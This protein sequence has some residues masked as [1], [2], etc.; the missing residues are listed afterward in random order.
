MNSSW[1]QTFLSRWDSTFDKGWWL[2]MSSGTDPFITGATALCSRRRVDGTWVTE[3][4]DRTGG[5]FSLPS[6]AVVLATGASQSQAWLLQELVAGEPLL[7]RFEGKTRLSGECLGEAGA[8]AIRESLAGCISPRAAIVGSSHSAMAS[9]LVC[10]QTVG[11]ARFGAGAITLMHRKPLRLTYKSPEEAIKD[12]FTNFGAAD[13]CLKT[14]RV[15][16]LAGFRSDSRNLLRQ[17]L[18]LGGQTPDPGD[19]PLPVELLRA[20]VPHS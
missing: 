10:L 17:C 7:P 6:R 8:Q 18:G 1:W 5:C 11:A 15:F 16:P 3:C 19:V 13:I 20:A 9:A 2:A 4:R 14:G 12:G